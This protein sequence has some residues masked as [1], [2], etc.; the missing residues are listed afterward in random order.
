MEERPTVELYNLD[1]GFNRPGSHRFGPYEFHITQADVDAQSQLTRHGRTE[2]THDENHRRVVVRTDAVPGAIVKTA[3]V[4]L[5]GNLP[6]APNLL[7]AGVDDAGFGD[8]ALLLSFLTGRQVLTPGMITGT[9]SSHYGE[10]VVGGNYFLCNGTAWPQVDQIAAQG[11]TPALWAMVNSKRVRDL[12]GQMLY[13]SSAFDAISTRWAKTG[14]PKRSSEAKKRIN[15]VSR[16]I[17]AVLEESFVDRELISYKNK[18]SSIFEVS[19]VHK[20]TEFLASIGLVDLENDEAK[21]RVVHINRVRNMV[22]HEANIP[23][24]L[25]ADKNR[26]MEIAVLI[27]VI[28]QEITCLRLADVAGVSDHQVER[29][30]AELRSFFDSGVFRGQRVFDETFEQFSARLEDEWT[31][32]QADRAEW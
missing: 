19:A 26:G 23:S 6:H 24:D 30:R 10:R 25:H 2:F 3:T 29:S 22:V 9:E 7:E 31:T 1:H 16:S 17:E 13:A 12:I 15:E 18:I 20:T 4:S 14:M 28:T 32:P 5:V 21:K 8:L 27:T 11:L